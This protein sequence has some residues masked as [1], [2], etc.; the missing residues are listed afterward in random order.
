MRSWDLI[1]VFL[2]LH[3]AGSYEGASQALSMDM[4]TV[5]RKIQALESSIGMSLFARDVRGVTLRPGREG[6]IAAAMNMEISAEH[7]Q[8]QSQG[9]RGG[10]IV[11]VTMQGFFAGLLIRPLQAFRAENPEI[12]LDITTENHLVDVETEGVDLAITLARPTRGTAGIRKVAEVPFGRYA[13]ESRI[14]HLRTRDA[15]SVDTVSLS[16]NFWHRDH[17][18][19]SVGRRG[20]IRNVVARVDNYPLLMQLCEAGMGVATLPCFMAKAKQGLVRFDDEV[21]VSELWLVARRDR[22]RSLHVRRTIEF[23]VRAFGSLNR[24]LFS[25]ERQ[26]RPPAEDAQSRDCRMHL[27]A[28]LR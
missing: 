24:S 11:R 28:N 17:E 2:A 1:R 19:G 14:D 5:R 13:A 10:G 26:Q 3:R 20:E 6:L 16:A 9:G 27:D 21:L 23:L 18:F 12:L 4:S 8:Q 25:Q 7:F 22:T 15:R